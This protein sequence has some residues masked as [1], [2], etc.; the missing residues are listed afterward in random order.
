MK[1][2]A[3]YFDGKTPVQREMAV[4]WNNG[5]WVLTKLDRAWYPQD[6]DIDWLASELYVINR[7]TLE[8]LI[9]HNLHPSELIRLGLWKHTRSSSYKFR[10]AM[11]WAVLVLVMF[12]GIFKGLRPMSYLIA[13]SVPSHNERLVFDK[14]IPIAFLNESRCTQE[15]AQLML[16]SL[17]NK[18]IEPGEPPVSYEILNWKVPNAFAFPGRRVY[19]TQGL[20]NILSHSEQLLAVLGHEKGHVELRHSLTETIH[21]LISRFLWSMAVG[22]FSGALIVDLRLAQDLSDAS[23]SRELESE[24]DQFGAQ[25][26][27]ALGHDPKA[28]GSAL[29]GMEAAGAENLKDVTSNVPRWILYILNPI[30]KLFSTHP[31]TES[32]VKLMQE[33]YTSISPREALSLDQWKFL[34][35]SCK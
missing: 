9:F 5:V 29:K 8:S 28:L 4:D 11:A 23:Y 25:K 24:A 32:R 34:Q 31:E 17:G 30:E 20:L 35:N 12:F 19:V 33:P 6:V 15:D 10:Q 21:S 16:Q 27:L 7:C 18:L 13:H 22:D 2:Q 26:L 14:I 3:V 1:L